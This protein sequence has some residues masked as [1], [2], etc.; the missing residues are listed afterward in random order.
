MT[1]VGVFQCVGHPK[2][3]WVE[4]IIISC[5]WELCT[6]HHEALS[7]GMLGFVAT[8]GAINRVTAMYHH[9]HAWLEILANNMLDQIIQLRWVCSMCGSLQETS[10]G[11][12]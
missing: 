1:K 9:L 2:E 12:A 5:G 11:W 8:F 7:A 3:I 6:R 10:G 4:D